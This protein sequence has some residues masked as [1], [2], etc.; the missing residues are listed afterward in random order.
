MEDKLSLKY[1]SAGMAYALLASLSPVSGLYTS[2]YP[3]LVYFIF[4]TC[5]HVSV[6]EWEPRS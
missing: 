6:G 1:V 3:V 2:F 4:G 5:K